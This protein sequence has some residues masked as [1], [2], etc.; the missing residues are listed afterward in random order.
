[1]DTYHSKYIKE[2]HYRPTSETP[3]KLRFPGGQIEARGCMLAGDMHEKIYLISIYVIKTIISQAGYK[4]S[5][6]RRKKRFG[7]KILSKAI[8]TRYNYVMV[9]CY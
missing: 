7:K 8:K 9:I 6:C 3:F 5:S 2:G 1:M 4:M